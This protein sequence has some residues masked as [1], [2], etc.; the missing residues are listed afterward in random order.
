ML[1]LGSLAAFKQT[2]IGIESVTE[3]LSYFYLGLFSKSIKGGGILK[4]SHK[5]N[6]STLLGLR[7][8][9]MRNKI[10]GGGDL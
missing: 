10:W 4:L 2:L 9:Q 6:A 1:I 7:F 5:T 3:F 8:Y